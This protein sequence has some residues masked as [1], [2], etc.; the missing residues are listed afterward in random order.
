MD[1]WD[2]LAELDPAERVHIPYWLGMWCLQPTPDM[3]ASLDHW[4]ER[5]RQVRAERERRAAEAARDA[6]QFGT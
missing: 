5:L 4:N 3:D 1:L 2:V 6:E